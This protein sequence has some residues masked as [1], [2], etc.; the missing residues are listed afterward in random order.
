[1]K[2]NNFRPPERASP[3]RGFT[4]VELLVTVS[5]LALLLS[6]LLPS[7]RSARAQAKSVMCQ[8]NMRQIGVAIW[9]YWTECNSRVPYVEGPMTNGNGGNR[10]GFGNPHSES[11]EIDPFDRQAW[12]VS[13]A[14]VLMPTYVGSNPDIF[15][16]PAAINGWPKKSDKYRYTY[17]PASANQ[18]NGIVSPEGSYF[19]ENFGFMDGRILRKLVIQYTGD[20]IIDAQLKSRK[21]STYL[22]DLVLRGTRVRGPHRNGVNVIDRRMAVEF[23]SQEW[24]YDYLV[25]YGQGVGF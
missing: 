7:F 17:R 4:L 5:I 21:Q 24:I 6:I 16:C 18:P 1:M 11:D 3:R 9:N 8:S 12:P 22:R 20:P 19:R 13:L 25:G 15:V 10:P 2:A 14:N 23:R